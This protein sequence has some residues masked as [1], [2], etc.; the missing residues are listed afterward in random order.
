MGLRVG[1]H[2]IEDVRV[3]TLR[4][5][6]IFLGTIK[7]WPEQTGLIYFD[8]DRLLWAGADNRVGVTKY[9]TLTSV[10]DWSLEQIEIEELL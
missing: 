6:A 8:K 10:G 7:I 2:R 3:G 5:M 4:P 9:N 1:A